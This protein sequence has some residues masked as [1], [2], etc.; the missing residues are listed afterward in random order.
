MGVT[1]DGRVGDM[2]FCK[3]EAL[4]RA[5]HDP[6]GFWVIDR[7]Q[8]GRGFSSVTYAHH[9]VGTSRVSYRYYTPGPFD[10]MAYGPDH[11]LSMPK[12][13]Y[14]VW[15]GLA[16][17]MPDEYLVDGNKWDDPEEWSAAKLKKVVEAGVGKIPKGATIDIWSPDAEG[18]LYLQFTDE[19]VE[20]AL[21]FAAKMN[22]KRENEGLGEQDAAERTERPAAAG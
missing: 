4:R 15:T 21:E 1:K 20:D 3:R 13:T 10:L 14:S 6:S 9:D 5:P 2:A 22:Q 16:F 12:G 7:V 19:G 18:A 17:P 11:P 8:P